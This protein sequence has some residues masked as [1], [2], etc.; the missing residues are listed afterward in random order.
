MGTNDP[1]QS[2]LGQGTDILFSSLN[3]VHKFDKNIF[4]QQHR[5]EK[6]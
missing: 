4:L 6:L 5:K 3:K 1:P 2:S